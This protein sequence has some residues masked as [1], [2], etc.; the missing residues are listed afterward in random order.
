MTLVIIKKIVKG[1]K[2]CV[3]FNPLQRSMKIPSQK[4]FSSFELIV[5]GTPNLHTMYS[6]TNLSA[7]LPFITVRGFASTNF[8]ECST[9]I[10]KNLKPPGA[11]AKGV[12]QLS[13]SFVSTCRISF[14]SI[15]RFVPSDVLDRVAVEALQSLFGLLIYQHQSC[16][17]NV[18]AR[19]SIG[20]CSSSLFANKAALMLSIE[21]VSTASASCV[22]CMFFLS[23]QLLS[24]L[25]KGM[26]L[27]MPFDRKWLRA[28]I[29]PLRLC[30]SLSVFSCS[31]SVMAFT[32]E[33]LARTRTPCLVM[34]HPKNGPSLTP[35]EHFFGLSFMLI[36]QNFLKVSLISAYISS[37]DVLLITMS[38]IYASR[39]TPSPAEKGRLIFISFCHLNLVITFV[40]IQ[41][42]F[43]QSEP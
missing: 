5:R 14:S 26:D 40:G 38:S 27:L 32:L 33:G 3:T 43:F 20:T 4:C 39:K 41:E 6:H 28:A 35:K 9:A 16:A 42:A 12:I 13:P 11:I 8:V 34:R 25:K 22:Y 36:D 31:T 30:T 10:A 7:C 1:E 17:E 21:A 19:R 2:D 37:S 29:F 23:V 24:T 18:E 15:D